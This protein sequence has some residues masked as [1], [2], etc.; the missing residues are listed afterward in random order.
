MGS[1]VPNLL[2][3]GAKNLTCRADILACVNGVLDSEVIKKLLVAVRFAA[4]NK[5]AASHFHY[6]TKTESVEIRTD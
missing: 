4:E 2:E 1:A 5:S 3:H 6:A